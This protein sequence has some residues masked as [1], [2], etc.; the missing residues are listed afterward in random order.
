MRGNQVFIEQSILETLPTMAK[1][2]LPTLSE[3]K[4]HAFVDEYKRKK[5]ST[6]LAYF[7]L[8]LCLGMPYGYLGKWG[9]QIVYWLTGFDFAI[10]FIILLFK[11]SGMVKDYNK[12]VAIE[13]MRNIVV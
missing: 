11:L 12:D 8:I 1:A 9:L 6:G 5:K 10:W 7:F 4:Q 3:E 2:E 13:V